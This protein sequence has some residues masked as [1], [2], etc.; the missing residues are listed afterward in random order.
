M[1]KGTHHFSKF[2]LAVIGTKKVEDHWLKVVGLKG[3]DNSHWRAH[4]N[5]GLSQ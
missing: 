2:F 3:D 1:S 4:W 5:F